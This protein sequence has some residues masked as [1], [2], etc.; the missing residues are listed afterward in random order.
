MFDRILIANRGEISCRIAATATRLGIKTVAVYSASDK[1]AKHVTACDEAIYIGGAAPSESYLHIES[2][3]R[4]A[5]EA[6]VQA[7]HPGYGFLAE[8]EDFATACAQTGFTFIG[9]PPSAI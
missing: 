1:E 3:I 4:A 5:Q 8:R 9:P 7:I 6:A 2:I